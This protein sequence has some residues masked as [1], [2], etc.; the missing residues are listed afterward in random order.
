MNKNNILNQELANTGYLELQLPFHHELLSFVQKSDWQNL[1]AY[2][3]EESKIHGKFFLFLQ[4]YIHFNHLEH[5]IAFRSAPDDEDGIWHDDGSRLMAFSLS[6]N[7]APETIQGGELLFR[8]KTLE[9]LI[10]LKPAPFGTI[11]LFLTGNFGYDHKVNQVTAGIRRVVA[12][13]CSL[14]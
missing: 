13:W 14:R 3:I 9:H 1:D 7:L 4:Q 6:L 12:G 11:F 2:F 10:S 8:P 5:M